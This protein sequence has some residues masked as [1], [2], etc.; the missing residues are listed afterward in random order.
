MSLAD[1]LLEII[2]VLIGISAHKFLKREGVNILCELP[3]N[4]AQAALGDEVE[5][6]T[7]DG[8]VTVRIPPAIESGTV[9]RLKGRGTPHLNSRKCGDQLITVRVVTPRSLNEK[10]RR[11][12]TELAE[13][14]PR[15]RQASEE[16]EEVVT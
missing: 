4:F 1:F 16:V 12:F 13:T 2:Q 9:L 5:V 15:A 14:L 3:I 7:L 11:L 6:P 8:K 10:Q